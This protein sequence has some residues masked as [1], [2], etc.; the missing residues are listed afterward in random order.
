VSVRKKDDFQYFVV[1]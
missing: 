1:G